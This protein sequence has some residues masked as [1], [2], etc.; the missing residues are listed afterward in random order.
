MLI[1]RNFL[2]FGGYRRVVKAGIWLSHCNSQE[3]TLLPKAYEAVVSFP[4]SLGQTQQLFSKQSVDKVVDMGVAR[5]WGVTGPPL[6][7]FGKVK[8]K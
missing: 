6:T 7:N 8:K 4:G 5:G 2:I 3:V 1:S